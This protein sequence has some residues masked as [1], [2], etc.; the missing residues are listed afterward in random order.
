MVLSSKDFIQDLINR[1]QERPAIISYDGYL[2]N[3]N[4]RTAALR[5]I[6]TSYV[7]C[8][9]LPENF[10]KKEIF[11]LELDLQLSQDFKEPY[12]WINEL[13]DIEQGIKDKSIEET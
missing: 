6:E 3:G 5:Y 10:N 12:H 13:I 9:V 7:D 2:V 1:G 8:V 11:D 4:R